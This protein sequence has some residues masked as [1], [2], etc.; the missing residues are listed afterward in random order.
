MSLTAVGLLN[1]ARAEDD[2]RWPAAAARER[3]QA[4]R[5][6]AA[7]CAVAEAQERAEEAD[8][9]GKRGVPMPSAAQFAPM[10]LVSAGADVAA[11]WREDPQEAVV[12]VHEPA[13]DGE[14]A[15][16]QLLEEAL[17]AAVLT[18][19]LVLGQARSA[20]DPSTAAELLLGAVPH[21][22]LAVAHC[23]CRLGLTD[24]PARQPGRGKITGAVTLPPGPRAYG[25]RACGNGPVYTFG[26]RHCELTDRAGGLRPQRRL[27]RRGARPR[28]RSTT[29]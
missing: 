22:A 18:G 3:V 28:T 15:A 4:Q 27:L 12:L 29:R 24:L 2:A 8:L 14:F 5:T 20:P 26:A 17:D 23:I 9:L 16:D 25:P 11:R 13:A 19:L 1:L 6:Y 10:E 21:F 7:R